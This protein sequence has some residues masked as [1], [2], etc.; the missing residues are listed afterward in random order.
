M[1]QRLAT[2]L[3][4]K[5][6]LPLA[7]RVDVRGKMSANERILGSRLHENPIHLGQCIPEIPIIFG[8]VDPRKC[9][10]KLRLK[11]YIFHVL[12]LRCVVARIIKHIL[13]S[14]KEKTPSMTDLF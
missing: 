5:A 1:A 4:K 11:C 12:F 9:W 13:P 7:H 14:W 6:Q 2:R 10:T 8:A 3:G